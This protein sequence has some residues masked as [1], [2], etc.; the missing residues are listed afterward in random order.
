MTNIWKF[1]KSTSLTLVIT[2]LAGILV[3]AFA[4]HLR[5][6]TEILSGVIGG[7]T[8]ILGMVIAEWLRST[9]EQAETT[10]ARLE[11]LGSNFQLALFNAHII[12]EEPLSYENKDKFLAFRRVGFE[13]SFFG[14]FYRWPQP[15]AREVRKLANELGMKLLALVRDAAENEHLWSTEKRYQLNEEFGQLFSLLAGEEKKKSDADMRNYLQYR[16]TEVRPGMTVSWRR[17]AERE[18]KS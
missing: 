18:A 2:G 4:Y 10:L 12:L 1:S 13:L 8:I 9:R 17:Q 3:L 15:H 11:N 5:H 6:Y 16:E 7:L 14:L